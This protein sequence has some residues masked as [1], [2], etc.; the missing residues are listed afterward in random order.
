[1]DI[2]KIFEICRNGKTKKVLEMVRNISFAV[3]ILIMALAGIYFFVGVD[4]TLVPDRWIA[5]VISTSAEKDKLDYAQYVA[6]SVGKSKSLCF[7]IA[8]LLTFG[9]ATLSAV[10]EIKKSK[11]WLVYLLKGLAVVTAILFVVFAAN[12]G[13]TYLTEK[14]FTTPAYAGEVAKIQTI[15]VISVV[16]T[17]LGI[18][19]LLANIVSNVLL[20]IEE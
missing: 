14:F 5:N 9:S 20:G 17:S 2:T 13:P 15:Q 12:F 1:M 18:T 16:I 10:S 6:I 11:L 19:G 8:I 4:L 7:I 3:I